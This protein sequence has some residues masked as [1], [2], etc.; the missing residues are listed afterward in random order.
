MQPIQPLQPTLCFDTQGRI[1][2][3]D[4]DDLWAGGIRSVIMGVGFIVVALVLLISNVAGGRGWWWSMLFPAFSMLAVGASHIA[5]SKRIIKR[6]SSIN[7]SAQNQ[8]PNVQTPRNLSSPPAQTDYAKPKQKSIY[9]TGELFAPPSVT[10][11]TTRHLEINNEG[12]T[13]SLPKEVGK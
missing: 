4:P 3:N 2:S 10:E 13:M 11:G 6:Q 7:S 5:R 8:F 12:E 9:D 1:K